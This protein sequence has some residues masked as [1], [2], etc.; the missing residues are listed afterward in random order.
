MDQEKLDEFEGIAEY[1]FNASKSE[2][3]V[4]LRK[5]ALDAALAIQAL[6]AEVR[7]TEASPD[8]ETVL[9]VGDKVK[10]LIR[11]NNYAEGLE[12]VVSA[13]K[14]QYEYPI[15]VSFNGV[16]VGYERHELGKIN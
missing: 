14:P 5:E 9:A 1:M 10:T 6:V 8:T 7:G 13:I 11:Y 16:I 4:D 12:G 15:E 3:F 2:T